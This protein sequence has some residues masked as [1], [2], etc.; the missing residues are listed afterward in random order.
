[1]GSLYRLVSVDEEAQTCVRR[2]LGMTGQKGY[3]R[4][5][6]ITAE[7]LYIVYLH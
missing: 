4:C 6:C 1:M 2:F 7:E 5:M 3:G